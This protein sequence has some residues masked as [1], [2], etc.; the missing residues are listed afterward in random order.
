MFEVPH[1]WGSVEKTNGGNTQARHGWRT[2]DCISQ[3]FS[4][5]RNTSACESLGEM[6]ST[7]SGTTKLE[8]VAQERTNQG[9]KIERTASSNAKTQ[10]PK[11]MWLALALTPQMGPT[12]G[13]RLVDH[14]G[15]IEAV[16]HASLTTLEAAGIPA[17]SAQSIFSGRSM[18]MA[19]EELMKSETA[20]AALIARSDPEYPA[21]LSEIY[22][23]PLVLYVKGDVKILSRA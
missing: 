9:G 4:L 16:F 1:K 23:P 12:R 22:D 17:Q 5:D 15:G 11:L 18:A 21:L 13:R 2:F 7:A 6:S 8:A 10:S 19:E 20:G 14:M 3:N